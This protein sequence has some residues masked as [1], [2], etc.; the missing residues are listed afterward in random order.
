VLVSRGAAVHE[1]LTDGENAFLFPPRNPEAL[2]AKIQS[3]ATEPALR[4]RVAQQGMELVRTKYNWEQFARQVAQVFQD[5]I[6]R[7]T[8][9]MRP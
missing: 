9:P 1:V 5:L 7:D 6:G 2:A 3:V 4:A 8:N